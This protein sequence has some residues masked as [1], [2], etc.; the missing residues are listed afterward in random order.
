MIGRC[1]SEE[2]SA[3]AAM[4]TWCSI[5]SLLLA[6]V[7]ML[8]QVHIAHARAQGAAD[9]AALSGADAAAVGADGCSTAAMI[10]HANG[11][12]VLS[13]S[14]DGQD[15]VIEVRLPAGRI[16]SARAIARAGPAPT[17]AERSG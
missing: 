5:A 13:C 11:A 1:G 14:S 10:A 7:V 16:G 9:L 15:V 6:L 4:L 3:P 12:D 17:G 8:G 2:G